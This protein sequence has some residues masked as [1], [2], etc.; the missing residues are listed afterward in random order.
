MFFAV[1]LIVSPFEKSE[2]IWSAAYSAAL[3]LLEKKTKA[4]EYAALQKMR[5]CTLI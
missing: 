2:P 4:A 3:V 5:I 1:S